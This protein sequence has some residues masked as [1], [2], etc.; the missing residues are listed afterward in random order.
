MLDEL[1]WLAERFKAFVRGNPIKESALHDE[2]PKSMAPFVADLIVKA[3]K[4]SRWTTKLEIVN[5]GLSLATLRSF[6]NRVNVAELSQL[7]GLGPGL[8]RV[9][10]FETGRSWLHG[11]RKDAPTGMF[12]GVEYSPLGWPELPDM[13]EADLNVLFQETPTKEPPRERFF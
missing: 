7:P 6:E 3:A 9:V 12:V 2:A 11:L 4:A 1:P 13:A 5:T 8:L 10:G